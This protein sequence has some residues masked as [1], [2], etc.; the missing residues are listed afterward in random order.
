[1][2]VS[3]C[4]G[5]LV[6]WGAL[7]WFTS[8]FPGKRYDTLEMLTSETWSSL[9]KA[10]LHSSSSLSLSLSNFLSTPF[11]SSLTL[12]SLLTPLLPLS[13][14]PVL[15]VF[16]LSLSLPPRRHGRCLRPRHWSHR[17]NPHC[18]FFPAVG[19]SGRHM[20]L[21]QQVWTP[22]VHRCQLLW[23]VR[24]WCQEQGH[25]GGQGCVYVSEPH[26][27]LNHIRHIH[28]QIINRVTLY[29]DFCL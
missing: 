28:L 13:F 15:L 19:G 4:F 2:R 29:R 8:K 12:L 25:R 3:L 20:L 7:T 14:L 22:H 18:R 23:E 6:P 9:L 16:P 21:P 5:T 24:P 17:G 11:P 1:M 26:H 10:P 27:L